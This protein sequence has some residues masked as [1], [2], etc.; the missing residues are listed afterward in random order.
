MNKKTASKKNKASK[1]ATPELAKSPNVAEENRSRLQELL[2]EAFSEGRL[3]IEAL[4]RTLGEEHMLTDGERYRLDWA[5][6][7]DA[8]KVLQTPT[9]ATLRPERDKSINFDTAEHVFIEG[10]NLEVLKVLQKSYFGKVKMIYIDP[11]YNTGNDSFIY[12]DRF[13]ESKEDYLRRIND[14][15]DDGRLMREG[16]FRKNSRESG[17]Y[18]S[19]WL[20]MMLPRL[21]IARNLMRDDGLIF[22]S[23]DDNEVHN[24]RG[25]MSEI[26]GEENFIA[27]ITWQNVYG[28]GAKAKHVVVQHE[29]VLAYAKSKEKVGIIDLPP[30]PEARKMYKYKDEKYS[31]R[32]P[33][34]TQ[35]L[36]TTSMDFRSNLRFPIYWKGDEIWPEKQWQW[37]EDRVQKALENNELVI[38]KTADGW[39]VRYKQYLRDEEGSERAS[40][41]SSVLSGPWSQE[42]TSEIR[43]LFGDNKIFPFP[44]PSSLIKLLLG[45]IW[46]DQDCIVMDFFAG[47][48]PTAQALFDLNEEF[49]GKR[50]LVAVQIPEATEEGSP[51]RKAGFKNIAEIGRLRIQKLIDKQR[52]SADLATKALGNIG[53]KSF[54]L[55]PSS[56]PQWRG[57]GLDSEEALA[58]QLKMFVKSEKEGAETE[59]VLYELLLKFGYELTTPV[60]SVEVSGSRVFSIEDGKTLF[61]LEVFS[62]AMIDEIVAMKPGE[63]IA[64]D[65]VFAD[66]DELKTNFDLQCRDAGIK[67]TCI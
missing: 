53:L 54:V 18:H 38:K 27:S 16:V 51:S 43:D 29:Y 19:N 15:D 62:E 56:F 32:G 5:G 13:Q 1:T 63:V 36:A 39:S 23:C 60:M 20:N 11:P 44:K 28:G 41:L 66:S 37:S 7:S 14:L 65:S 40:K 59:W 26:Y 4:K 22:V 8:Y 58:D 64:L 3:D 50:K 48:C 17:H 9:T 57:D 25:L 33:Y 34:F 24:L 47:S 30:N 2:P 61:V 42:G 10:E 12:P 45:A 67:F 49:P 31:L 21:Y 6:K 35:P 55:S 52:E 46:R